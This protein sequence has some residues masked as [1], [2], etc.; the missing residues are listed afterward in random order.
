MPFNP[1]WKTQL[2]RTEPGRGM[3]LKD[4]GAESEVR[5]KSIP[6]VSTSRLH[7]SIRS[8]HGRIHTEA[9]L[10]EWDAPRRGL[11]DDGV[12]AQMIAHELNLRG[13]DS[14][15]CQFCQPPKRT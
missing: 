2:A 6:N 11:V 9:G 8:I 13:E 12:R 5:S 1:H 14:G 4:D 3:D 15:D 10:R 7:R